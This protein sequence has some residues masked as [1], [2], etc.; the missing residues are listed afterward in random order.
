ML[1]VGTFDDQAPHRLVQ[2][3]FID[4]KPPGYGYS[5]TTAHMTEAEMFKLFASSP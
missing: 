4:R 2:E 1:S 3:I 5:G